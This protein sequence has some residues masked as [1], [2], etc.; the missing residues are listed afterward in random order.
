M[1]PF[2]KRYIGDGAYIECNGY[3]LILTTEDGIRTTNTV[4]IDAGDIA[5]LMSAIS[6]AIKG[7]AENDIE[8]ARR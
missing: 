2:P 6:F 4:V 7:P 1:K 3:S 5:Q 8:R